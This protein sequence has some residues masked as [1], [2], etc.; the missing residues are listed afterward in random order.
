MKQVLALLLH[1][2]LYTQYNKSPDSRT[3][4][5]VQL[6]PNYLSIVLSSS[7]QQILQFNPLNKGYQTIQTI[8]RRSRNKVLPMNKGQYLFNMNYFKLYHTHYGQI[9]TA[10]CEGSKCVTCTAMHRISVTYH[11]QIKMILCFCRGTYDSIK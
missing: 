4:Q 5:P 3:M 8:S 6:S 10:L 2:Q 1:Q 9:T 11:K 7:K